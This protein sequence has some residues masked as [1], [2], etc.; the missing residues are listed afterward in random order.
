M[1]IDVLMHDRASFNAAYRFIDQNAR[2]VMGGPQLALNP[3]NH[4]PFLRL[5]LSD[6]EIKVNNWGYQFIV[7]TIVGVA[8]IVYG[9]AKTLFFLF[10]ALLCWNSAYAKIQAK[11][12]I[13][14][15]G[16]GVVEAI[17]LVTGLAC[18]IYDFAISFP[19][20][21]ILPTNT[22]IKLISYLPLTG[23]LVGLARLIYGLGC[24]LIYKI[25][26]CFS[27]GYAARVSEGLNNAGRGALEILPLTAAFFIF[28]D[29]GQ[30][31]VRAAEIQR[32]NPDIVPQE[33]MVNNIFQAINIDRYA[34][35]RQRAD[36]GK[37]YLQEA[38]KQFTE[39]SGATAEQLTKIKGSLEAVDGYSLLNLGNLTILHH[40]NHP[41]LYD[42]AFFNKE[43]RD[44]RGRVTAF[45]DA[46]QKL[47][48]SLGR[49]GPAL[50]NK[51]LE[52]LMKG[53]YKDLYRD[54]SPQMKALYK[55]L[56][57]AWMQEIENENLGE[58]D[59]LI[60]REEDPEIE[61][62]LHA[63]K[64]LSNKYLFQGNDDFYVSYNALNASFRVP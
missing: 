30:Y 52:D 49:P 43:Y 45:R 54:K 9:V 60:I 10:A 17:P 3:H 13:M 51:D 33:E 38:F 61:A 11:D 62:F 21:P 37:E 53:L 40:L 35:V 34:Q 48:N 41:A 22:Y 31:Q 56:L 46:A 16:R 28:Y 23:S 58:G 59:A 2:E 14:H 29:I 6:T 55:G 4:L 12:G 57:D 42:V 15:I 44:D 27:V 7:G 63:V 18:R 36:A 32:E 1:A 47:D 24:A 64:D 5:D 26:S 20:Q 25:A 19:Y 39:K 50:A 8:R